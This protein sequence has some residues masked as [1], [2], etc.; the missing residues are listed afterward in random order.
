MAATGSRRSRV[1]ARLHARAI[2]RALVLAGLGAVLVAGVAA[3]MANSDEDGLRLRSTTLDRVAVAHPLAAAFAR[4]NGLGTAAADDAACRAA[5]AANRAQ[6]FGG[7]ARSAA[8][9][10]PSPRPEAGQAGGR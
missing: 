1:Y 7:R 9:Q 4:C 6:F 5:W 2:R 8:I 3:V 10:S